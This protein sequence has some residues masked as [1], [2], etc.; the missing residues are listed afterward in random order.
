M[1]QFTFKQKLVAVVA[2]TLAG[3]M[4]LGYVSFTGLSKLNETSLKVSA[5][6]ANSDLLST[7]QLEL[8]ATENRVG[9]L[10][11]QDYADFKSALDQLVQ[12]YRQ[13]LDEAIAATE[14]APL[15][16]S[17]TSVATLFS[18]YTAALSARVSAQQVIG[19]DEQSGLLQPVAES[20]AAL[21]DQLSVFSMLLQPFIVARQVEK[22]FLISPD[23]DSATRLMAQISTVEETVK[24]ADFYDTFGPF[25][26]TYK[27][28]IQQLIVAAETLATAQAALESRQAE[29]R[30][31]SADTQHYL[32]TELL[33]RAKQEAAEATS[34]AKWTTVSVSLAVA[35]VISALLTTTALTTNAS[36]K[37]IIAQLQQ[38]AEGNLTH[39]LTVKSDKP[40]EFDQ[41]ASAVNGMSGD[42]RG[43]IQQ[44]SSRQEDLLKQSTELSDTIQTI[45]MSNQQVSDQSNHLA[46]AT[47]E[48][49][50]TTEEVAGRILS[51]QSDSENAHQSAMQGGE[52][53]SQAMAALGETV[54]VVEESSVQLKTLEQRSEEID[55]IL[56]I[57]NDL[58]D[59]TN[60]L[61]LNAAIEA[62]RAG[63][64]G[65]GFS[66]VA[67]EVRSLAERTVQ[68]TGDITET[69]RAIQQ[70]TGSVMKVMAAGQKSIEAI[71]QQG[72]Q[73]QAAV[74]TIERQTQQ[75]FETSSEIT[76]AI[77]EVARTTRE[78]AS[79]MDQIA[80]AV[81][82]NSG[83]SSAIVSSVDNLKE[84]AEMMG[85]M[86]QR[87]SC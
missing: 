81:E 82:Q 70:Q 32:K 23:Q 7:L 59:Q 64:A 61:A 55:N 76:T 80:S 4:Y 25:I 35:V 42:L 71:K 85:Q 14:S 17:M 67:D 45:A 66:V 77:E 53:I 10:T 68:A 33:T 1:L 47:E 57:I 86:T 30:Q 51:L 2:L 36:L 37:R 63:E 40:D 18:D 48:I 69:V 8:I 41:V 19:F 34:S 43:V 54:R 11:Q 38:I 74:Q 72:E 75:A 24:D 27:G 84:N 9:Q 13:A 52:T 50:A 62:A 31:V 21:E 49:S 58:A 20:A 78:M 65:R 6:T 56:R 73:A 3:I 15:R 46:G 60:L 29:F 79:N 44:V 83:A 26:E 39:T 5:L 16:E 22:E 12:G 87:F 28:N